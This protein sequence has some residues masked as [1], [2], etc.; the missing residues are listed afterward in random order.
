MWWSF[1]WPIL[2]P[3]LA[4]L[5]LAAG[6]W[7][8]RARGR[9]PMRDRSPWSAA[10]VWAAVTVTVAFPVVGVLPLWIDIDS[11][12]WS[13]AIDARFAVPLVL[14]LLAVLALSTTGRRR[15]LATGASLTPRT[16]RSFVPGGWLGL[17]LTV[18]AVIAAIT[19]AAGAASRPDEDG[20]YT[21]Y[22]VDL[23]SGSAGTGIYGWHHSAAPLALLVLLSA[24]TWWSLARIAR[25]PLAEDPAADGAERRQ[26]STDVMRVALGALLLHLETILASLRNTSML[27]AT[28]HGEDGFFLTTG[29]PFSALT[30]ALGVLALLVGILG[31]ALWTLAALPSRP[32]RARSPR[33]PVP[34]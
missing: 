21:Q 2:W 20:R 33:S 27:T 23:G 29:T 32:A 3:S 11:E 22:V 12:T 31:L 24:G 16:W 9:P 5:V 28:M 19:L 8:L 13:R 10:V 17:H 34:S 6:F 14:G 18:L 1:I 15:G 30:G 4:S 7:A 25:P 26:R